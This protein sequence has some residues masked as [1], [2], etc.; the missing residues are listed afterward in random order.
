[1]SVQIKPEIRVCQTQDH[2][3]HHELTEDDSYRG[4]VFENRVLR[5]IFGSDKDEVIGGWRKFHNEECHKL[6][7]SPN[8][9]RMVKS[10]RTRWVGHVVCLGEKSEYRVLVGELEGKRS[11]GRHSSR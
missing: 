3:V 4:R 6:Y 11:L 9:I 8:F 1:M 2:V 7:S 5:R 10:R